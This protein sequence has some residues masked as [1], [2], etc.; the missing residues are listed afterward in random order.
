MPLTSETLIW[1]DQP[2]QN[3]NEALPIGNGRL[4]GMV[5]GCAQQEKSNSTR[6]RY[7]TEVRGTATIRMRSDIFRSSASCCS[8]G[9]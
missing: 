9:G 8:K 3:W 5:F 4:G 7:G 1:F 6:I 2:A